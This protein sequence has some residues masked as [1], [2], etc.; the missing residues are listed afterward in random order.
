MVHSAYKFEFQ[1]YYIPKWSV[2]TLNFSRKWTFIGYG[3]VGA[4]IFSLYIIYDTQ[5]MMGGKPLKIVHFH[6]LHA[7]LNWGKKGKDFVIHWFETVFI[8]WKFWCNWH[9]S[10][11][12]FSL[13]ANTSTPWTL[14]STCSLPSTSTW[15]SSTSSS[16]SS[17]SSVDP[18]KDSL[19]TG[20]NLN[21][22]QTENPEWMKKT[23]NKNMWLLENFEQK[24]RKLMFNSEYVSANFSDLNS[25]FSFVNMIYFSC[26]KICCN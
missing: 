22:N 5:L 18:E 4:L 7:C 10:D 1:C 2:K 21:Q 9:Y 15:T 23:N 12:L 17:W 3:A 25:F 24:I 16:T 26:P 13:Q 6:Q 20:E 11:D 19:A 14:R 8:S